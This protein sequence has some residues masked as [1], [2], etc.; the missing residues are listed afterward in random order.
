MGTNEE[1]NA[2]YA[3]IANGGTYIKPKLYTKVVDHDGNV[4]LDNTEPETKQVIKE[5]TAW[6]LTD[7]MQD[8]VT[9]GTG[10]SV[11]FGGMAIAGKTGT[12]SDYNDVW[13][14]ITNGKINWGYTGLVYYNDIW[15]YVSGG[16]IDWNYAGLVYYNDVWFYVSG[17]MIG[18]DYT[19]LAPRWR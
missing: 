11:N 13:F 19:G 5:T 9:Q 2:A 6:L 17:G 15:F 18:W 4:I 16:M 12:T 1:L 8:V 14:Y 3:C 10:A 7:A